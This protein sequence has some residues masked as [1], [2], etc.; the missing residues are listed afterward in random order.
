MPLYEVVIL[1]K[2]TKKEEE[3]GKSERLVLGP[4]AVIAKDPQS[5]AIECV[6]D[7]N[8]KIEID[9]TRMVVLTRPFV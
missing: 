6:L 3:D 2:P 8:E 1:E 4:K 9:R 5:A 7:N